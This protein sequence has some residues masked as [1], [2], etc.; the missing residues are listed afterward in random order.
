[1]AGTDLYFMVQKVKD[2]SSGADHYGMFTCGTTNWSTCTMKDEGPLVSRLSPTAAL[3]SEETDFGGASNCT[4]DFMGTSTAP[5]AFG[6]QSPI[7]GLLGTTW[8]TRTLSFQDNAGCA[9]YVSPTHTSTTF[10]VYDSN[11][12]P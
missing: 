10:K 9:E 8:A 11:T 4:N 2:Q 3:V 7:S 5:T 1:M 6:V 12:A